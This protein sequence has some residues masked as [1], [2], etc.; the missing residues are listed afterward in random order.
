MITRATAHNPD[1]RYQSARE[2]RAAL[3]ACL[4]SGTRVT[5]APTLESAQDQQQ[6]WAHDEDEA[7]VIDGPSET[8][9]EESGVQLGPAADNGNATVAEPD[10]EPP[11]RSA[12]AVSPVML[13]L[14]VGGAV[15]CAVI[16]PETVVGWLKAVMAD[17]TQWL[18]SA[19]ALKQRLLL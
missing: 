1:E 3:L 5:Y 9:R 18:P 7:I 16:A 10:P 14:L 11:Q 4:P 19:E 15:A 2:M 8:E 13:S 17:P 6:V 12:S